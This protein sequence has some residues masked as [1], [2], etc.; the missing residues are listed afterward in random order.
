MPESKSGALPLGYTPTAGCTASGWR[1]MPRATKPPHPDGA[2]AKISRPR[3]RSGTSMNNPDPLPV[4]RASPKPRNHLRQRP[5]IGYCRQVTGS[6]SFR[7]LPVKRPGIVRRGVSR[8][9]SGSLKIRAVSTH[10]GGIR[11]QYQRPG[12]SSGD[13]CSPV[14]SA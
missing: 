11:T 9:N 8:V 12:R 7:T 10:T 2:C 14:P 4:I 13:S 5:T 6:R 3:T 1:L